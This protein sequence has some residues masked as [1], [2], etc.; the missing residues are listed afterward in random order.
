MENKNKQLNNENQ[1]YHD[2]LRTKVETVEEFAKKQ[3]EQ[4]KKIKML[5]TKIELLEKSLS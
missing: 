4:N 1:K 3:Y 2:D 5:K